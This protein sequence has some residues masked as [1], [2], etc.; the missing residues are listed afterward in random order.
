M[1]NKKI[2]YIA[3]ALLAGVVALG[4]FTTGCT[5]VLAKQAPAE[6]KTTQK[7][8]A[9]VAELA[10]GDV[11]NITSQLTRNGYPEITVKKGIPVKWNLQADQKDLNGCNNR[12][13]IPA[14]NI[15][16]KL[17]AGDNIIEFTPTKDGTIAYSCWMGMITSRINVVSDSSATESSLTDVAATTD[18]Q[19]EA[20]TPAAPTGGSCCADGSLAT[21][22]ADGNIPTDQIAIAKV[23]NGIQEVTITVNDEGYAPAAVVVQKGL[24]TVI[25]FDTQKLNGCNSTVVFPELNGS[26]DLSKGETATPV[27]EPEWD[28]VF[29]CD[30]GMLHGYVK[31]VDD[32][33]NIDLDSIKEEIDAF[34]PSTNAGSCCG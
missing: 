18:A 27:L 24:E 11:Q 30:M 33:K 12:L 16:K 4:I 34:E 22:F 2:A 25:R 15:E 17:Q 13:I 26:L 5:S 7:T 3:S 32:I 19:N 10:S 20:L 9:A 21:K 29:E 23:V 14:Y 6:G 8:A 31:V 1:R 28:F